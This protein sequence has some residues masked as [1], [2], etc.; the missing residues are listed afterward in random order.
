MQQLILK[1]LYVVAR[2]RY[3]KLRKDLGYFVRDN[4]Y[5]K[6]VQGR[7]IVQ[8]YILKKKYKVISYHGEFDQ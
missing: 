8:D 2:L 3:P 6:L 7:H 1:S 5:C 4:Y